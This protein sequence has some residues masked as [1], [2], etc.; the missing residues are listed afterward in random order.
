MSGDCAHLPGRRLGPRDCSLLRPIIKGGRRWTFEPASCVPSRCYLR[1]PVFRRSVV[2]AF[3]RS[4]T[5]VPRRVG[6]ALRQCA[7]GRPRPAV[8]SRAIVNAC[9][10]VSAA[11]ACAFEGANTTH[12]S[13]RAIR[14]RPDIP[15][16]ARKGR[17]N[18]LR[19]G[20]REE[21]LWNAEGRTA[22]IRSRIVRTDRTRFGLEQRADAARVRDEHGQ[23]RDEKSST[24]RVDDI[25]AASRESSISARTY[26]ASNRDQNHCK[27]AQKPEQADLDEE[28]C[29][30]RCPR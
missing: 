11:C 1:W 5:P 17:S 28:Q 14:P 7:L 10:K 2:A 25:P 22:A 26:A 18:D 23:D 15:L 16:L 19:V 30:K 20:L 6:H 29:D 21:R 8:H 24:H 27:D 4:Q 13:P 12:T 9:S 3:Q